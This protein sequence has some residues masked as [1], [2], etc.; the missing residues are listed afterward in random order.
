MRVRKTEIRWPHKPEN[1]GQLPD[2]LSMSISAS[3][4]LMQLRVAE[5]GPTNAQCP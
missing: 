2:P 1:R 4:Y 5:F 3:P